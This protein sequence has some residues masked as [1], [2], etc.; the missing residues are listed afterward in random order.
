MQ[1]GRL[2]GHF[3]R[4]LRILITGFALLTPLTLLWLLTSLLYLISFLYL[5][6]VSVSV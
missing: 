6:V 4:A 5:P 3:R 1:G 2:R